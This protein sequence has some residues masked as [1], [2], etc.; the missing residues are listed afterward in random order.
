[1]QPDL[2]ELLYQ[3]DP[4]NDRLA[5]ITTAEVTAY[6]DEIAADGLGTEEIG[7]TGGEPFMNPEMIDILE[8]TLSRSFRALVLTNDAPLGQDGTGCRG[9]RIIRR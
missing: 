7:F 9:C 2:R 6:L 4:T 3:I 1:M 5:Y 8:A